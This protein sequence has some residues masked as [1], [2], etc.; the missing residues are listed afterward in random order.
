MGHHFEPFILLI[1]PLLV[2]QTEVVLFRNLAEWFATSTNGMKAVQACRTNSPWP[3]LHESWLDDLL[4]YT[5]KVVWQ[6]RPNKCQC[7]SDTECNPCW[8][9]LGLACETNSKARTSIKKLISF[10]LILGFTASFQLLL[11]AHIKDR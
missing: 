8:R 4:K 1:G 3:K 2:I 5:S 11:S 6:G 9:W 10:V 7:G